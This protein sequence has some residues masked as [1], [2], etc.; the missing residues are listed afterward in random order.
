MATIGK[1]KFKL[2]IMLTVV[3]IAFLFI[4]L[5]L[6]KNNPNP[7]P[8]REITQINNS[9]KIVVAVGDIVCGPLELNSYKGPQY[10]QSDKTYGLTRALHPI[11]VLGL[12]DLQYDNGSYS[13]FK[14]Y[15]DKN[16]GKFK[17]VFYPSPGNHEYETS[18]AS[19]YYKFFK[20]S[21]LR[22]LN[23]PI[24]K[25]FYSFDLS[26]WHFISLN[27]NCEE[28]KCGEG[29]AQL[30]WLEQDLKKNHSK[31]SIAFWH[32]PQFS[33]ARKSKDSRRFDSVWSKL[34][35]YKTD[36]AL[37]GHDHFYERQAPQNT[38]GQLDKNGIRQFIVGT[39]GKS[40]HD[41]PEGVA[42]RQAIIGH[43]FG[44]LKLTLYKES[45]RWQFI[46]IDKKVLDS[47]QA[48]C[49]F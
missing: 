27:S 7:E 23:Q 6:Y 20:N 10:C 1:V 9:A 36:I 46:S 2:I 19:G 33:S 25:G 24:T 12:G 21:E 37:S 49:N 38:R 32:H 3:L 47:G 41:T 22:G 16:W 8:S 14:N 15:F 26:G 42:T 48:R 40:F 4:V 35:D 43:T 39:G 34:S 5:N 44:V 28:I 45:Y 30:K 18:G 11:A 29:G 13:Q 31:C 17:D